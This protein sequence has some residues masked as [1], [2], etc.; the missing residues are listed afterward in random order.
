MNSKQQDDIIKQVRDLLESA[1]NDST[2]PGTITLQ[3]ATGDAIGGNKVVI[4]TSPQN[5]ER[6]LDYSNLK[7]QHQAL[8]NDVFQ[9]FLWAAGFMTASFMLYALPFEGLR[10]FAIYLFGGALLFALV[11]AGK[12]RAADQIKS[13]L[14]V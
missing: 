8:E 2:Q 9:T 11:A 1:D 12:Q 10:S 6:S 4:V 3:I 13:K 7:K 5:D 14:Y